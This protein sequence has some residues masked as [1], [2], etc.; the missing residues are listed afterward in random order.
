MSTTINLEPM[1]LAL[2]AEKERRRR[3]RAD[4]ESLFKRYRKDCL[5]FIKECIRLDDPQGGLGE[6]FDDEEMEMVDDPPEGIP[7]DPW[8]AQ[9]DLLKVWLKE[10]LSIVLKARQLGISWLACAFAL[11]ICIF[12][13]GK[14]VLL[15]SQG[16][17]EADE[18]LRRIRVMWERLP[19]SL[20]GSLPELVSSGT[21]RLVWYNGSRIQSL[22][23]TPKSG[24]TFTA[25]LVIMDEAAHMENAQL[26]YTA[27][28][29]TI[30]GG[31]KLIIIS[32]ANGIGNLYQQL[33]EAAVKGNTRFIPSFLGWKTRPDRTDQWYQNVVAEALGNLP[34]VWQEYPDTPEEAFQATGQER[35]IPTISWWDKCKRDSHE[36]PALR[37]SPVVIALDAAIG[38]K[39]SPSDCFAIVAVSLDPT[40]K[41]SVIVR[42]S[43][44]W[45]VPPGM[46]LSFR[47]VPSA[48]GP[49]DILEK[50]CKEFRVICVTYDVY[51][52][53]D[54]ADRH[55]W[56]DGIWWDD[57]SQGSKRLE[58]DRNML[59]LIQ[60]G[61]YIH[62][63][64]E[65]LREHIANADRKVNDNGSMRIVQG[66]RGKIDL[67]VALSMASFQILQLNI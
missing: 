26:L 9:V 12:H 17:S 40:N 35:F 11:W 42:Y 3:K 15:F 7:F 51:Q 24:R 48:P 39:T 28:K 10:R 16:Q 4:A 60:E 23:A 8:P 1:A 59:T 45:Q 44:K 33:W 32:T 63:G 56:K 53:A 49:E 22:P 41:R 67:A 58:A 61:R 34:L 31:G 6:D 14:V 62:Q 64:E 36:V 57:F 20:Q 5:S 52:L 50:L 43:Q 21:S 2:L 27:L 13:K 46:K 29:P 55:M 37:G 65:D 47:G 66:A 38:R 25:S 54:M 19:K 18:L 30:D